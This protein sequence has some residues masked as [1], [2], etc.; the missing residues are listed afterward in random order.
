[1][2]K[3]A[4]VTGGSKGIGYA[5]AERLLKDGYS[6]VTCSRHEDEIAA[7]GE[8]LAAFGTVTAIAADTGD[9]DE[10]RRVIRTCVDTYGRIDALVNNAGIYNSVPLLDMSLE[11]WDEMFSIN[12]RGPML[13]GREAAR[14]MKD[15]GGGHI[16]NMASTN[17]IL[18]EV[19]FA[20]YNS[21]KAALIMLTKCMA[22][23]WGAYNIIVNAIA[24]GWIFTPMAAPWIGDLT[25]EQI[26][27]SFPVKRVGQPEE[28]AA[29]AGFL[30]SDQNSFVT[31]ETIRIDGGLLSVHP[32]V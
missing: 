28:V 1:M 9:P 16:V 20:H 11:V 17:G 25:Q 8:R 13:L 22:V 2:S 3:A 23:E 30:C 12:L 19:D 4:V 6:V 10:C 26:D 27:Q 29:L 18:P 14:H 7:A 32:S 21:S 31:G 24:P 15:Q 5:C